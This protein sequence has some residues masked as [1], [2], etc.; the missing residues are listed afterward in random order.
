M[1]SRPAGDA[2]GGGWGGRSARGKRSPGAGHSR[3]QQRSGSPLTDQPWHPPFRFAL[4][5]FRT[6]SF[7]LHFCPQRQRSHQLGSRGQSTAVKRAARRK[8]DAPVAATRLPEAPAR[9]RRFSLAAASP[10]T[11]GDAVIDRGCYLGTR[12]RLHNQAQSQL[13]S[14]NSDLRCRLGTRFVFNE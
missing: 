10:G 8:K 5:P 14:G 3:G 13:S 7:L 11:T 6:F 12:E 1:R 4:P 2:R 9:R